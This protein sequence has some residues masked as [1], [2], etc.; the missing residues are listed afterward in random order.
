MSPIEIEQAEEV[1]RKPNCEGGE[2]VGPGS[3]VVVTV[4]EEHAQEDNSDGD[5]EHDEEFVEM[6]ADWAERMDAKEQD[7]DQGSDT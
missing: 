4:P 5:V 2:Q 6:T 3:E 7:G 1:R